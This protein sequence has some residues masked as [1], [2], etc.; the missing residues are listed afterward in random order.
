MFT[1]GI[2]EVEVV[3]HNFMFSGSGT[4][5]IT[6]QFH[7]LGAEP[8]AVMFG[9]IWLSQKAMGMARKSLKAVGFDIDKYDISDL[10]A[11]GEALAGNKCS[12]DVRSEEYPAGSG[13][14]NLKVAFINPLYEPLSKER[15]AKLTDLLRKAK[16]DD[17]PKGLPAKPNG[18]AK[19]DAARAPKAPAEAMLSPEEKAALDK[20]NAGEDSE[21]PF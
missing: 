13:K 19:P 17:E 6:F 18:G 1:E 20:Q 14:Y 12:I 7:K 8:E 15:S 9:T 2:H 5:G 21:I 4:P 16:K 10:E 11:N 3:S